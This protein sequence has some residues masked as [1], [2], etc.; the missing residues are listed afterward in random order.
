MP[1]LSVLAIHILVSLWILKRLNLHIYKSGLLEKILK[2]VYPSTFQNMEEPQNTWSIHVLSLSARFFGRAEINQ[3]WRESDFQQ[4]NRS[5][6]VLYK[7]DCKLFAN[8]SLGKFLFC[9]YQDFHISWRENLEQPN[10]V[11]CLHSPTL[12]LL[13]LVFFRQI[14]RIDSRIVSQD[15]R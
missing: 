9:L 8:F 4:N 11:I 15:R 5:Q 1:S 10:V 7:N 3:I 12:L 14:L 6:V 13:F 2:Q